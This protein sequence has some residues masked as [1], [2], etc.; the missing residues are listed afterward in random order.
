MVYK[1]NDIADD[2]VTNEERDDIEELELSDEEERT[3]D[4]LKALRT[5]LKQAE[6]DKK[7]I[8]DE[9][10]RAR[11]DFLNARKRL[12]EER[13]LDKVRHRKQFIESLLPLCDSFEMAMSNKEVWEK[14]DKSWRAGIEG[15]NLQLQQLLKDYGVTA[16]NPIGEEFNPYR[17]DAVSTEVVET[18]A[19]QDTVITVLQRGY[20]MTTDGTTE[21]IRPARVTTGILKS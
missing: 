2:D 11:A 8:L 3:T 7:Q 15:I 12:D 18:E 21:I 19:E 10:Q 14:A 9:S 1:N 13:K 5:K 17:H 6:E 20:E 4:K 16:L